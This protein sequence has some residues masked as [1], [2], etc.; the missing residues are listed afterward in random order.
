[1]RIPFERDKITADT[2]EHFDSQFF[3]LFD[4]FSVSSKSRAVSSSS[5]IGRG[6]TRRSSSSSRSGCSSSRRR[7]LPSRRSKLRLLLEN[8]EKR[9]IPL[10]IHTKKYIYIK[11]CVPWFILGTRLVLVHGDCGCAALL[12]AFPGRTTAAAVAA[13]I[14]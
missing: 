13:R 11:H 12:L 9:L 14:K 10:L 7:W 6:R 5:R 4:P 2:A 8:E 1:M 3:T